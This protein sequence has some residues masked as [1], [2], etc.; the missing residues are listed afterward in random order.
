MVCNGR[1]RVGTVT[2]TFS[3]RWPCDVE[4]TEEVWKFDD[5]ESTIS[6]FF[7][8]RR[9]APAQEVQAFLQCGPRGPPSLMRIPPAFIRP[10]RLKAWKWLEKWRWADLGLHLGR[11]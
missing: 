5:D 9:R 2:R 3:E 10:P 6:S 11:A 8:G 4:T 7:A 1:D